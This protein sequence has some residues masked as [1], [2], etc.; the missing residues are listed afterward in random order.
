MLGLELLLILVFSIV[1]E[2]D[3]IHCLSYLSLCNFANGSKKVVNLST[4]VVF[5]YFDLMT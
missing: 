3:L 4:I 1:L 5:D 2:I